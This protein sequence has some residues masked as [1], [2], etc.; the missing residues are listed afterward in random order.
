MT[1]I[2]EL[3][4][5]EE[6]LIAMYRLQRIH[7][8]IDELRTLRGELPI[9]VQDLEDEIS[10]LNVRIQKLEHDMDEL[11]TKADDYANTIKEAE[12]Y[13]SKYTEQTDN[14]KNSREFNALTKEIEMQR[15]EI[16]LANRRTREAQADIAEKSRLLAETQLRLN[17]KQV[18]LEHKREE[19][20]TI[21]AETEIEEKKLQK[22]ADRAV[23]D[24]EDRMLTAYERIR[25]NYKN[26]LAVVTVERDSC[27]GCFGKIPPQRQL[28]L[29]QRKKIILCEHCGR[30]LVDPE[31]EEIIELEKYINK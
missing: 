24:I 11:N 19:L 12:T 25:G 22:A 15:L 20:K 26:G 29:K 28:E 23:L 6:K 9:E 7:S 3:Q 8:K 16:E 27:G 5:P 31:V 30:I 1:K 13:I 4:T 18:D 21:T 10:G 17:S 2:Q 14:V